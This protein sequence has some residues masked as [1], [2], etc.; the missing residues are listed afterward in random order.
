MTPTSGI[1]VIR[2]VSQLC[3]QVSAWRG[4]NRRIALVPTMGALHEGHLALVRRALEICDRVIVSLFVNP[5]Q[6]GANEDLDAYPRDEAADQAVLG[7]LGVHLLYAP[8]LEEMYPDGL[9]TPIQVPELA[10]GLCG[11]FRPVH[12]QGHI[13][14]NF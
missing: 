2:A 5:T 14:K 10:E 12:L 9:V 7:E 3:D 11:A 8:T 1:S 4:Q 6:F 13:G